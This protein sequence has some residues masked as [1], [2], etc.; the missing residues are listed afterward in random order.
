MEQV[1]LAVRDSSELHQRHYLVE[2]ALTNF[3]GLVLLQ[4]FHSFKG[5][6]VIN[7]GFG[8]QET[9][10]RLLRFLIIINFSDFLMK[11]IF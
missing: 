7:S 3:A 4:N 8:W 10:L 6:V 9:P 11:F 1:I 5:V 2:I